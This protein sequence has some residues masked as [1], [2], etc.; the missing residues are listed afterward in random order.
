MPSLLELKEVEAII[1][2]AASR[3]AGTRG[4]FEDYLHEGRVIVWEILLELEVTREN[5]STHRVAIE[6]AL[7]KGLKKLKGIETYG[8]MKE[9]SLD[10]AFSAD[11]E[12]TLQDVIPSTDTTPLEALLQKEENATLNGT[13]VPSRELLQDLKKVSLKERTPESQQVV[14]YLLVQLL[15]I[16]EEDVPARLD[17]KT[18]VEWGLQGWL[19]VFFNNS[20]FR[21]V[22]CAY[23]GK[24][25]P[26][27]MKRAPNKYWSGR[28][29]K[30][31]A[32]KVL[33]MALE[34]TN[35]EPSQ[36]PKLLT[37]K[38]FEEFKLTSPLWSQFGSHYAYLN[39][40]YPGVYHCWELPQTPRGYF[41]HV[42]NVH[43][44]VKWL[45]EE[46]LR[47]PIPELTVKEIWRQRIAVKITKETFSEHG[48]R[49]VMAIYKSP[50][51]I[52]RMVYPGKFL[53]WSFQSK[54]KWRGEKGRQLAAEATRWFVE[55]YL[56]VL[57][58]SPILTWDMF[59]KNGFNGMISARGLGFNSSPRAALS[60]A[61][62]KL[63]SYFEM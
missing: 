43:K 1:E 38:F 22:N 25:L 53:Q 18:F 49:E 6:D 11:N 31:R 41:D 59:R 34:S 40:A 12:G 50:E 16:K 26:H 35:I 44:A 56:K 20:P 33:R 37:T 30:S 58:T 57:P 32:A 60:N 29:G 54:S 9:V 42:E 55:D 8:S 2:S 36:Y 52:L 48:L 10:A 28:G 7:A 19:W 61:Y 51:P 45:V 4:K 39:A 5:L 62:P 24:F 47:F 15:G 13:W 17:Y 14:V 46:K 27:H 63:S 23:P 3:F 21:A